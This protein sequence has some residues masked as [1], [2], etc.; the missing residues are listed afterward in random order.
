MR[1]EMKL[2]YYVLN[3]D[4]NK[5]EIYQFNIFDNYYVYN[6]AIKAVVNYMT[7][8]YNYDAYVKELRSVIMHE[9]WSRVQ[10][11]IAVGGLFDEDMK[12]A[13]K[14]DVFYQV[15]K[16]L[17]VIAMYVYMT[18]KDYFYNEDVMNTEIKVESLREHIWVDD[19]KNEVFSSKE[20]ALAALTEDDLYDAGYEE[21]DRYMYEYRHIKEY[22]S[23]Y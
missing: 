12:H 19:I 16:N 8:A 6:G 9:M 1:N 22:V 17:N 13:K 14:V 15:E 4:F 11:E 5:N 7:G 21:K 18:A 23:R 2:E 20:N 10:Y 3:H